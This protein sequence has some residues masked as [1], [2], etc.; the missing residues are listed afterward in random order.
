M[1]KYQ[2]QKKSTN[3]LKLTLAHKIKAR[4]WVNDFEGPRDCQQ[5]QHYERVSI[6]SLKAAYPNYE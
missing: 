1:I 3:Q 2:K 4:L 5:K 6:L